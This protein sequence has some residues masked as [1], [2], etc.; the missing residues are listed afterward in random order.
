MRIDSGTVPLTDHHH[1]FLNLLEADNIHRLDLIFPAGNFFEDIIAG[2]LG[3]FDD[4]AQLEFFHS[5]GDGEDFVLRLPKKAVHL[6]FQDSL[7]QLVQILFLL[8]NLIK[9]EKNSKGW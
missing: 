3:V 8:E 6:D 1:Y 5:E 7:G 4:G 9:N 2:D